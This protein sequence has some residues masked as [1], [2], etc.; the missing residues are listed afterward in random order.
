M[1]NRPR[2]QK[3]KDT[4]IYLRDTDAM[5]KGMGFQLGYWQCSDDEDWEGNWCDTVACLAGWYVIRN[6]DEGLAFGRAKA[7]PEQGMDT[8][9][10]GIV[11]VG[12]GA[13]SCSTLDVLSQHFGMAYSDA[14]KLFMPDVYQSQTCM[15]V[16]H[17]P[18]RD[19]AMI[20]LETLNQILEDG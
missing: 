18:R 1:L 4:L 15:E 7:L 14:H 5:P 16:E 10:N 11:L 12:D 2:L 17:V 19:A 9:K 20:A 6:P 13:P 8:D 3:L